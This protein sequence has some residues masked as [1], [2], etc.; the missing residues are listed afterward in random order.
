MTE[1]WLGCVV[2]RQMVYMGAHT[3]QRNHVLRHKAGKGSRESSRPALSFRSNTVWWKLAGVPHQP[4]E[5]PLR[6]SRLLTDAS[7]GAGK[8]EEVEDRSQ[9]QRG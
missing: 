7:A 1:H 2:S 9:G 8:A 3:R 5:P 6:A 4:W